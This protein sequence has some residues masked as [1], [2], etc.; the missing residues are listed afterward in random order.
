MATVAVCLEGEEKEAECSAAAMAA[1]TDAATTG[2]VGME[3]TEDGSE[4]WRAAEL[5]VE[6][7]LLAAA[8][9]AAAI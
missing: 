1:R 2:A 3:P 4:A 7:E 5:A 6:A 9:A 8:A